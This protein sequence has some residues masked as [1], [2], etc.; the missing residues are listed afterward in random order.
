M[1]KWLRAIFPLWT[2]AC[3]FD[4]AYAAAPAI[5]NDPKFEVEFF[6]EKVDFYPGLVLPDRRSPISDLLI[7]VKSR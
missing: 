5:C 3:G 4:A 2:L 6:I 1:S 7:W